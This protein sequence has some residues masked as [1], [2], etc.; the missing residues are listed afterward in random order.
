M[1][2]LLKCWRKRWK[3]YCYRHQKDTRVQRA[4]PTVP[5]T[6]TVATMATEQAPLTFTQAHH[7]VVDVHEYSLLDIKMN[8]LLF[9]IFVVLIYIGLNVALLGANMNDQEYIETHYYLSFHLSSFWGVFIF[10]LIEA[11]VFFVTKTLSWDNRIQSTVV[12][13]NVMLTFATA[14]LF[15][16]D[17]VAYETPAHYMEYIAQILISAVN[18]IFLNTYM[19]NIRDKT[20]PVYKLRYLEVFIALFVL[21]LSILTL[22]LYTR[23][24]GDPTGNDNSSSSLIWW[25]VWMDIVREIGPERSAHFAEFFNEICNGIFALFYT[26]ISYTAVRKH[27]EEQYHRMRSA[28]F[29]PG[30]GSTSCFV[31]NDSYTSLKSNLDV[32]NHC[33]HHRIRNSNSTFL[34]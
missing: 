6:C 12:L 33:N 3:R 31:A 27:L 17:P 2:C 5:P 16:F 15:T 29:Y 1:L 9:Y 25:N 32:S 14:L 7:L 26:M 11:L 10:A 22:F 8:R 18:L 30:T 4:I 13:C 23:S 34:V 24:T 28:D 20:S 21:G 19:N